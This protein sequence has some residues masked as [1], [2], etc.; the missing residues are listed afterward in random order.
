[1]PVTASIDKRPDGSAVVVLSGQITLG[2]SLSMVESQVRSVINDGVSKVVFDL[3]DV[4][5]LDSAGLGMLVYVY[6]SLAAKGGVLRLC[7]VAPRI[8]SL[9]ELT[10]TNTLLPIDAT[11]ADSLA[12]LPA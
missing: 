5:F 10:R 3:T 8:M 9:L 6:G 2:S 7:G 4:G 11:L 1:M 12:A